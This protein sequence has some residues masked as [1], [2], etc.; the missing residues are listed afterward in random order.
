MSA[1]DG[2]VASITKLVDN[3]PATE[4]WNLVII[5]D[6]YQACELPSYAAHAEN[7]I[8]RLRATP[9][10]SDLFAGI[11]V[12]RIDVA[13]TESGADDPGCAGGNVVT[14][15]TYFDATYCSLHNGQP[16]DRLLTVDNALALS[17][18]KAYVVENHQVVC[19]VNS[20][21]YGGSGGSIATCSVHPLSSKIAIHELGHSAF[22]LADEYG[23]DGHDTPPDEPAKPN[24][25][26]DTD[27]ITNKWRA[28]V[29]PT[30]SMPTR[31]HPGCIGSGCIP[32]AAP[33]APGAVGTYEGA[34][35]SDCGVYRPLNTCYMN[36][37][38]PFCPVCAGVIRETL[39][40]FQPV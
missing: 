39:Q 18:A 14:A 4:R 19:I 32:P 5:G 12:Y 29:L 37:Y 13:S 20:T 30:T 28:L 10:F 22:G 33:S 38:N 21:K 17:V 24:V 3:G 31:C 2:Y 25:T 9:P 11:N 35:W 7:F 26:R 27:R 6:G 36:Q 15:K 23:G 16:L 8:N 40:A 1:N 34:L